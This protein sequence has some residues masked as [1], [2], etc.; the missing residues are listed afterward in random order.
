MKLG[1][2]DAVLSSAG[3]P[4][5]ATITVYLRDTATTATI[6]SNKDGSVQKDNPF[7]TDSYGR[8]QFFASCGY[9][10]VQVSGTGITTYKIED[11]FIGPAWQPGDI[12]C[13]EGAVVVNDGEIVLDL[14]F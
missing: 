4:I 6:Y 13:N 3:Q 12:V 2:Y 5:A 1:Y 14:N 8:F 7:Q 9:Y 10:D 11:V